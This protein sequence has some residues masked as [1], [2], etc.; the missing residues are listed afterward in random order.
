MADLKRK[1]FC[2]FRVTFASSALG[3]F[4]ICFVE[5][6]ELSKTLSTLFPLG[7]FWCGDEFETRFSF[8]VSQF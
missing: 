1:T 3:L 2:V 6:A 8:L 4:T 7:M 5:I